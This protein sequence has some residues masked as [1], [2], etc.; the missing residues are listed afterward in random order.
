MPN[1]RT[2][3]NSTLRFLT[4]VSLV[5]MFGLFLNAQEGPQLRPLDR[6]PAK[7]KTKENEV[8]VFADWKN[9][10][11]SKVTVY[12]VNRSSKSVKLQHAYGSCYLKME[13]QNQGNK[14]ERVEPQTQ[15]M[16]GTGLGEFELKTGHWF[17]Q[18]HPVVLPPKKGVDNPDSNMQK[19]KD[20]ESKI[21]EMQ[22]SVADIKEFM[23]R[24]RL[25][26]EGYNE[27]IAK[28]KSIEDAIDAAEVELKHQIAIDQKTRVAVEQVTDQQK[29]TRTVRL[30]IYDT[31]CRSFSNEGKAVIDP[32]MAK[33]AKQD[34]FA[35][36]F[37]DF[38]TL[39]GIINGK[40]EFKPLDEGPMTIKPK[41]AAVSALVAPW[42]PAKE[43]MAILQ[44][45][46]TG[47]D[48]YL[49]LIAKSVL[50]VLEKKK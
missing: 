43:R 30:R 35:I 11:D 36:R 9:V 3:G 40:I 34:A 2:P 17:S 19:Q 21:A 16:C 7:V 1:H 47:E 33:G 39:R 20:L 18:T 5:L 24:A 45:L 28:I 38:E 31:H 8:G 23:T 29:Y 49:G 13:A 27:R 14:W 22:K 25:T 44:E 42:H 32:G 6:L 4:S 26:Q 41:Q 12:V 50:T 15:E 10:V 46:V 37:A 48:Q